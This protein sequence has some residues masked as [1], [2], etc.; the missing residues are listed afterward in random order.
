MPLPGALAAR[1]PPRLRRALRAAALRAGRLVYADSR[2][3]CPCCGGSFRRFA[4]F[5]GR[6]NEQCPRCGSL[7]RHRGMFLFLRD[8]L[9]VQERPRR[10]LHFA[11]EPALQDWLSRLPGEYVSADLDSP[12]ADLRADI[13]ALPLADE[14]FDLVLCSHVL[15]HVE[16][17]GAALDAVGGWMRPGG[18]LLVGVPN[19]DSVQARLGGARWYHLDV[20]RHRTHFTVTGLH[21][22]LAASGLQPVATHHLLL[23]HNPFGLWQSLVSR[24][25]PTQSWLYHALKRNA[26]LRAADLL[27]TLLALPLAPVALLV[28]WLAG[29]ARRG[30]TVATISR[31]RGPG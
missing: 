17:P 14:A 22:L 16:D 11:P 12:R 28:E 25:T 5:K 6:T 13:T 19:L 1:L 27:P 29:L 21:A 9:G 8:E 2:V 10:I 15:E 7:A 24:V 4:R 26:P 3:T 23:E 18:V 20:P 30:G 31:S